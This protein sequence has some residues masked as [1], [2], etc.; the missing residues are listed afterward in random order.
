MVRFLLDAG[1]TTPRSSSTRYSYPY[2]Y[3]LAGH[4]E[5][6][7]GTFCVPDVTKEDLTNH[8]ET[9]HGNPMNAEARLNPHFRFSLADRAATWSQTSTTVSGLVINYSI[10]ATKGKVKNNWKLLHNEGV[11]D[12]LTFDFIRLDNGKSYSSVAN[13]EYVD[14]LAQANRS[15]YRGNGTY[16]SFIK[17]SPSHQSSGTFIFHNGEIDSAFGREDMHEYGGV[18][19]GTPESHNAYTTMSFDYYVDGYPIG[20]TAEI[21]TTG[22]FTAKSHS[23]N[24]SAAGVDRDLTLSPTI[25]SPSGAPFLLTKHTFARDMPIIYTASSGVAQTLTATTTAGTTFDARSLRVGDQIMLWG[26]GFAFNQR[27][28]CVIQEINSTNGN[29]TKLK[30]LTTGSAWVPNKWDPAHADFVSGSAL[31]GVAVTKVFHP[32]LTFDGPI[33][34]N[35][36]YDVFHMRLAPMLM[37]DNALPT[38]D[39]IGQYLFRVGFDKTTAEG[40]IQAEGNRYIDTSGDF[41]VANAVAAIEF[42]LQ[43][44]ALNT[45]DAAKHRLTL[46]GGGEVSK[47]QTHFNSTVRN[48]HPAAFVRVDETSTV[49]A[50]NYTSSDDFWMDVDVVVD[51]TNQRYRIL[52]DA[53]EDST[54]WRNFESKPGGGSWTAADLY[55][56]HIDIGMGVNATYTP[57]LYGNNE[58][59]TFITLF[60]RIAVIEEL[61]NPV[62]HTPN[63]SARKDL[64]VGKMDLQMQVNGGSRMAITVFDDDNE[65]KLASLFSDAPSQTRLLMFK[66]NIDSPMWSG[67]VNGVQLKQSLQNTK[68]FVITAN[69]SLYQMDYIMPFWEVGQ[70]FNTPNQ[71]YQYKRVEAEMMMDNLYLGVAKLVAGS[72]KLGIDHDSRLLDDYDNSLN[73]QVNGLYGPRYDQRTRLYSGNPIQM[74]LGEDND[75]VFARPDCFNTAP[76]AR[77]SDT[78]VWRAWNTRKILGFSD[79][80]YHGQYYIVAHCIEHGLEVDDTFTIYGANGKNAFTIKDEDDA[81][82]LAIT[83]KKVI[84]DNHFAFLYNSTSSDAGKAENERRHWYSILCM[85]SSTM[86][87]YAPGLVLETNAEKL[88]DNISGGAYLDP[89]SNYTAFP[90]L[91]PFESWETHKT[92][93]AVSTVDSL[94]GASTSVGPTTITLHDASQFDSAGFGFIN[95]RANITRR[96]EVYPSGHADAGDPIDVEGMTPDGDTMFNHVAFKWTGKSGNQLTGCVSAGLD[97]GLAASSDQ[98]A[99]PTVG[100]GDNYHLGL[101]PL[102]ASG[103]DSDYYFT[104]ATVYQVSE[105]NNTPRIDA[106]SWKPNPQY[107]PN[108]FGERRRHHM[109][110]F[111]AN[112]LNYYNGFNSPL[113]Y[114]GKDFT[115]ISDGQTD[116]DHYVATLEPLI[117]TRFD[118]RAWHKHSATVERSDSFVSSSTKIRAHYGINPIQTTS[119]TGTALYDYQTQGEDVFPYTDI[120]ATADRLST[121]QPAAIHH[122][123]SSRSE[124]SGAHNMGVN[125]P[126]KITN[127]YNL[128]GLNIKPAGIVRLSSPRNS[129]NAPIILD[130]DDQFVTV[131]P[132]PLFRPSLTNN[133]PFSRQ[134]DW[135]LSYVDNHTGTN[136]NGER[137]QLLSIAKHWVPQRWQGRFVEG[138]NNPIFSPTRN[139]MFYHGYTGPNQQ[140]H[141]PSYEHFR[142]NRTLR[143]GVAESSPHDATDTIV[144]HG[145]PC[146]ML[147]G[148]EIDQFDPKNIASIPFA[149]ECDGL[150]YRRDGGTRFNL[151]SPLCDIFDIYDYD[152]PKLYY[153]TNSSGT[154]SEATVASGSI[155][156]FPDSGYAYIPLNTGTYSGGSAVSGPAANDMLIHWTGV[157]RSTNKLT[158]VTVT[159]RGAAFG[160]GVHRT[161]PI[162]STSAGQ[163][164]AVYPLVFSAVCYAQAIFTPPAARQSKAKYRPAHA[165]YMHDLAKSMWFRTVFG[166]I[167]ERAHGVHGPAYNV[168][169]YRTYFQDLGNLARRTL[170]ADTG[171]NHKDFFTLSSGY[172][173]GATTMVIT[174][175]SGIPMIDS[176]F[177]D[178]RFIDK[179]STTVDSGTDPTISIPSMASNNSSY[180]SM[181]N[182]GLIIEMENPDGSLDIGYAT[183]ARMTSCKSSGD[184]HYEISGIEHLPLP[185]ADGGIEWSGG[186]MGT[187][188]YP[189]KPLSSV[190]VGEIR[191]YGCYDPAYYWDSSAN[192]IITAF[193]GSITTHDLHSG[194]SSAPVGHNPSSGLK[195]FPGIAVGDTIFVGNTQGLS[196]HGGTANLRTTQDTVRFSPNNPAGDSR[197]LYSYRWYRVI[198]VKDEYISVFPAE[199]ATESFDTY[200]HPVGANTSSSTTTHFANPY[201]I[202]QRGR[203]PRSTSLSNSHHSGTAYNSATDPGARIC[204]LYCGD[205]TLSGVKMFK[206][207]HSNGATGRFRV[208]E[209]SFKHLWILWSDMRNDGTASA[210]NGKRSSSFGLLNPTA[211]NYK[212]SLK[213]ARTQTDITELAVNEDLDLWDIGATDPVTGAAWSANYSNTI[214]TY[215]HFHNWESKAGA[216]IVIDC[217]K[218]FNLNTEANGGRVGQTSG[219]RKTV[220]DYILDSSGTPELM[221]NY[222]RE[223]APLPH[224]A[225]YRLRYDVNRRFYANYETRLSPN[226][227]TRDPMFVVDS[228]NVYEGRHWP[229]DVFGGINIK[230][231]DENVSQYITRLR[232][233][234][235][236]SYQESTD[237]DAVRV[238]FGKAKARSPD[239]LV[240]TLNTFNF[241]QHH[242]WINNPGSNIIP[243]AANNH[244]L[245]STAAATGALQAMM[246]MEGYVQTAGKNTLYDFDKV[247][248]LWNMARVKTW[249]GGSSPQCNYDINNV[250]RVEVGGLVDG[251]GKSTLNIIK[252]AKAK[253]GDDT[254]DLHYLI[255]RDNRF[256]FRPS[257]SMGMTLNRNN[258]KKSDVS[259]SATSQFSHV[260]VF[261]NNGASFTD[262]PQNTPSGDFQFKMVDAYE[263]A[264]PAEASALA[265][266]IYRKGK[267]N[268]TD[269]TAE[270]IRTGTQDNLM[271]SGGRY[272]YISSAYLQMFPGNVDSSEGINANMSTLFHTS[273]MAGSLIGGR[274]N[275][276]DGNMDG[277]LWTRLAGKYGSTYAVDAKGDLY[278]HIYIG[279]RQDWVYENNDIGYHVGSGTCWQGRTH[280]SRWEGQHTAYGISSIDKAV[281]IV[282]VPKDTPLTSAGHN[283]RLRIFVAHNGADSEKKFKVWLVDAAYSSSS[284]EWV[285]VTNTNQVSSV[286][287]NAN[288]FFEIAIPTSYGATTDAK[289]TFSFNADY[290][291]DLV[292]FRSAHCA[293][294]GTNQKH[295]GNRISTPAFFGGSLGSTAL[296]SAS[297]TNDGSAF[298]LGLPEYNGSSSYNPYRHNGLSSQKC[299]LTY[300]S[301]IHIVNDWIFRPGSV[302]RYTDDFVDIDENLTI[303]NV[304]YQANGPQH[305]KMTLKLQK[306][307]RQ[308]VE[309]LSSFL[310]TL[311]PPRPAPPS[312]DGDGNSGPGGGG[313]YPLPPPFGP[314]PSFPGG[315][316]WSAGYSGMVGT[317]GAGSGIGSITTLN[318]GGATGNI[319]QLRGAIPDMP[320]SN[321]EPTSQKKVD[322]N[323]LSKTSVAM[324]KGSADAYSDAEGVSGFLGINRNK[325]H[326]NSNK[327]MEEVQSQVVSSEEQD[328]F[329]LGGITHTTSDG[330][331]TQADIQ[332]GTVFVVVPADVSDSGV[333]ISGILTAPEVGVNYELHVKIENEDTGFIATND[334]LVTGATERQTV[335]L[336]P[337]TNFGQMGSAGSRMKLTVSRVPGGSMI[338]NTDIATGRDAAPFSSVIVHGAS[339]KFNVRKKTSNNSQSVMNNLKAGSQGFSESNVQFRNHAVDAQIGTTGSAVT[340]DETM[341]GGTSTF[342]AP[343]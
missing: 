109:G 198:D 161:L 27:D 1:T 177:S 93:H 110:R 193:Q 60:D 41:E 243:E 298:P 313:G 165:S 22:S 43:P 245:H 274:M 234:L 56:Y 275:A 18:N 295:G 206:N 208:I 65:R 190:L 31:N 316:G 97:P 20:H 100:G 183:S 57:S 5:D 76:T 158:G 10:S 276:M 47:S 192:N 261:Y 91:A 79:G 203:L 269:V 211:D 196:Q 89:R 338:L 212:V 138:R 59:E 263:I 179:G 128:T 289:I 186:F 254:T 291:Y 266:S 213:F 103:G 194:N 162:S 174:P 284:D 155:W 215:T 87:D 302:V 180:Q 134:M 176:N 187:P 205:V 239:T 149:W 21:K 327:F 255:G 246:V 314:F 151:E 95:T 129:G 242:P 118:F 126:Q 36:D 90:M 24:D 164:D 223:V 309:S 221:D 112:V 273:T 319:Q 337:A 133:T 80:S 142:V 166:I 9:H 16:D 330:V 75:L 325:S 220:S 231:D 152:E 38:T 235:V 322:Y 94:S 113:F 130:S 67:I 331:P 29:I 107:F 145:T 127:A 139:M 296:S 264:S 72:H 25:R 288:G 131:G 73:A 306:E 63:I 102:Q 333:S 115:S 122:T 3:W 4:Y 265:A 310:P 267:S 132:R 257:Y 55:G 222:W 33:G 323:A 45:S 342:D 247:R 262:F 216:P 332:T 311:P 209:N 40:N 270:I 230:S 169:A 32:L 285:S 226:T 34:F 188:V 125:G 260:R 53:H 197:D 293:A 78:A 163:R 160:T 301:A 71:S 50:P 339:F 253:T 178:R 312:D 119:V 250:P 35:R 268:R 86:G 168:K 159:Q 248:M 283:D 200:G 121:F 135:A 279:E 317:T 81:D 210:D 39:K 116:G 124:A 61:N 8:I 229:S 297:F 64:I 199:I 92:F 66:D 303:M 181:T 272:G 304:K 227:A 182:G 69:D 170:I 290:C 175:H 46:K 148:N 140:T 44:H 62:S 26:A 294:D 48:L 30:D 271:F 286:E 278:D 318:T 74:Y 280:L 7:T 19:G 299:S 336:L 195:A 141:Y 13:N 153:D 236:N 329:S 12:W 120:S 320:S 42:E 137:S 202:S 99:T 184:T 189:D 251:R 136:T 201:G 321:Q 11:H 108:E 37:K 240:S 282:H 23:W 70:N 334:V 308:A 114:R 14:S 281:Q 259:T 167:Q 315:G 228:S 111:D 232:G 326:V 258:L 146:L 292:M 305:E 252:Q 277:L 225:K 219:G 224:T 117:G 85:P 101:P 84:D 244:S 150:Y 341:L 106:P 249:F 77:D 123:Y 82:G 6:F 204:K 28:Y 171:I 238:Y 307:E 343:E 143:K 96:G 157:N 68:E 214:T 58:L 147:R 324:T 83:V 156:S 104:G 154:V 173:A 51:F 191:L 185:N 207:S 2:T 340:K 105:D 54:G 233:Y 287:C 52:I 144:S 49:S 17:T 328:G 98:L 218:F 237:N 88:Y 15:R 172:T 241:D 335:E 300:A 256:E 217:S